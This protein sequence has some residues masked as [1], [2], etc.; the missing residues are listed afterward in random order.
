MINFYKI[1]SKSIGTEPIKRS[2]EFENDRNDC[3][4]RALTRRIKTSYARAH[5]IASK[6]RK[7]KKGNKQTQKM[8]ID[9]GLEIKYYGASLKSFIESHPV[10]CFF[11]VKRR[12]AFCVDQG[13]VF[14]D[15]RYIGKNARIKYYA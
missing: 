15:G 10:G 7:D 12:H 13:K 2:T 9:I 5:E 11:V 8:L 4:V 3:T 14:D 6:Y 1:A